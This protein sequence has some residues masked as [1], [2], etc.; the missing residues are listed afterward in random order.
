MD[1]CYE[2]GLG[3]NHP[4]SM[5]LEITRTMINVLSTYSTRQQCYLMNKVR[6]KDTWS[7]KNPPTENIN[8]TIKLQSWGFFF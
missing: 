6:N 7:T 3:S 5:T 8:K 1:W 4:Y 2:T